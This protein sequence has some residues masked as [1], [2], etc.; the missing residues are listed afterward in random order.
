MD[1]LSIKNSIEDLYSV[2]KN[3]GINSIGLGYKTVNGVQTDQL[4]IVFSVKDKLPLESLN[5]DQI[6]PTSINIGLNDSILTDVIVSDDSYFLSN[7]F[8]ANESSS[9]THRQKHRPLLGGI[10]IGFPNGESYVGTLGGIFRDKDDGSLVALTN[11]HVAIRDL[12]RALINSDKNSSS[13]N[14]SIQNRYILQTN[15]SSPNTIDEIGDIKRYYPLS[16]TGLNYVDCGLIGLNSNSLLSLS[17]SFKQLGLNNPSVL[18]IATSAEIDDLLNGPKLIIKSGRS[19]GYIGGTPP[20]TVPCPIITSRLHVSSSIRDGTG[21]S[22]DFSDLI[23]IRYQDRINSTYNGHTYLVPRENVSVPGDSG[24]IVT[25]YIDGQYKIVALLFAGGSVLP[26]SSSPYIP[27][28]RGLLCRI[29]KVL[30]QLNIDQWDGSSITTNP[31]SNWEFI[32]EPGLSSNINIIKNGKKYW[33]VGKNNSNSIYV[34]YSTAISSSSSSSLDSS[35]SSIASSSSSSHTSSSS[36]APSTGLPCGFYGWGITI[37][38]GTNNIYYEPK[39]ITQVMENADTIGSIRPVKDIV[40]DY[41]NA[42]LT[43]DGTIYGLATASRNRY[44]SK[45]SN[46]NNWIQLAS[47]EV[48]IYALNNIG[49]IYIWGGSTYT[50]PDDPTS[51]LPYYGIGGSNII[52]IAGTESTRLILRDTNNDIFELTLIRIGV[53]PTFRQI[54]PPTIKFKKISTGYDALAIDTND[55]AYL[56]RPF[57]APELISGSLNNNIIDISGGEGNIIALNSSGELLNLNTRAYPPTFDKINSPH[58][59]RSISAGEVHNLAITNDNRLFTFGRGADFQHGRGNVTPPSDIATKP[60]EV[61]GNSNRWIKAH[62][63]HK[64]HGIV[65]HQHL[66]NLRLHQPQLAVIKNFIFLLLHDMIAESQIIKV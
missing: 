60:Y 17:E 64:S 12:E 1:I 55:K 23:E 42:L 19:S 8:A 49:E 16:K 57:V 11:A 58:T 36:S 39:L 9:A 28:N 5:T 40:G 35:S 21:T 65:C 44:F 31:S 45:L 29:D 33:Q 51:F 10:S 53:S 56:L 54:N 50:Y 32:T 41:T 43:C 4:S 15:E 52:E 27:N 3:K 20:A 66:R 26:P 62:G 6:I 47:N 14:F 59:F 37:G 48:T 25:A 30:N 13:P 24:S 2:Y 18:P 22:Y 46:K 38:D 7:C 63:S 34:T 61:N